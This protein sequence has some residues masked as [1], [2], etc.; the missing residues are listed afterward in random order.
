[1]QSIYAQ[2]VEVVSDKNHFLSNSLL[3]ATKVGGGI[4]VANIIVI[5]FVQTVATVQ[6]CI[7]NSITINIMSTGE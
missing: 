1:M 2:W 3:M 6:K 7:L 4:H 5:M